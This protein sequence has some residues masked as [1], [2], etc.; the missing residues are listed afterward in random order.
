MAVN[1]MYDLTIAQQRHGWATRLILSEILASSCSS[2]QI[3]AREHR[4][5]LLRND[6]VLQ[7][8]CQRRAGI[9]GR[10]PAD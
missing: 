4:D 1:E 5:H 8:E 7:G 10:A 2:L 6:R 3:L 9:P